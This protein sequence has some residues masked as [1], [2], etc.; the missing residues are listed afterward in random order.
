VLV[1]VAVV[2]APVAEEVMFR[3]FVQSGVLGVVRRP[4]LA[5][6]ITA[7]LFAGIHLL[8]GVPLQQAYAIVPLFV[9]GVALG[10]AY[11]RTRRVWVPVV[12][13]MGFN[14]LNVVVVAVGM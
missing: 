3:V 10:W 12:M 11:E 5:V 8:G 1:A 13:H 4:G 7:A 9:F 14:L 2:G 6:V